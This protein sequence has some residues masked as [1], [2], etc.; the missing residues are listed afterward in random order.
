MP[1][2]Q[3]VC[4]TPSPGPLLTAPWRNRT[5]SPQ[6][7]SCPETLLL[8]PAAH[9]GDHHQ[10]QATPCPAKTP[11]WWTSSASPSPARQTSMLHPT[12]ARQ[13]LHPAATPRSPRPHPQLPHRA[14]RLEP[15]L[16]VT[17]KLARWQRLPQLASLRGLPCQ[18][19]PCQPFRSPARAPQ[20]PAGLGRAL[21][22]SRLRRSTQNDS[23]AVWAC[24]V[25]SLRSPVSACT[26]EGLGFRI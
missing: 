15:L 3:A 24:L 16:R 18:P 12:P 7:H 2:T 13:R 25:S 17:C 26:L 14:R 21:T 8:V 9:Q 22:C 4:R 5:P 10:A 19:C 1:P 23:R 20:V 6:M 11:R